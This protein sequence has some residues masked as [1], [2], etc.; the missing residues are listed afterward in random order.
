M[1]SFINEQVKDIEISGIRQF[2]NMV[3]NKN[4]ILSLTIGQPDFPTPSHVKEKTKEAIDQNQTTYTHNAGILSLREAIASFIKTNYQLEYDPNN[5]IIVTVG[6]SQAIDI[7]LRTIL[8][9]GDEVLLPGP[10]YP[11][12]EPLV[13]LAGGIPTFIDTRQSNFKLTADLIEKSITPNTKAVIIP[14]PSNPTG[15]TLTKDELIDI[16]TVVEKHN[17]FL[18]ADEIYSELV[19]DQSHYSIGRFQTI[20]DKVII[21]NGVSKSHSMT[22]FRIGYILAANWLAKHILKVHQYN[23]S[24]ASS[25]SQHGALEAIKNGQHDPIKMKKVYQERRDYVYQRLKEMNIKTYL[26]DGGFYFFVDV[27][28]LQKDSFSLALQLVEEAKVALVPGSAFSE[29]GEGFLRLSYAYDMDTLTE[30]LDRFEAFIS[31]L[32]S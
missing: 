15:V 8:M 25:I 2:F 20:R 7:T 3:G 29:Y 30:G 21:I 24:C 12:Y 10:V 4:D 31:K 1:E 17:I 18:I 22:G 6:A 13:K 5:E 9:K 19:Y 14:Y 26:P 27:S 23:V 11:G 16:A 32:T 28:H